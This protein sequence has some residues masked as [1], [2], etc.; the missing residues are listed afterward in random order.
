VKNPDKTNDGEFISAYECDPLIA[1]SEFQFAQRQYETITGR[2]HNKNSVIAY[3]L[4]QSFK[5]GEITPEL[6]NKLGY[7]LQKHIS[8]YG[9]TRD[10]Y[11]QYKK[12]GWNKKFYNEHEGEIIL[13]R[14]VKKFFDGL[15]YG[16]DKKLPTINMLKTEYAMILSEKKKL[17][18]EYK[19]ARENMIKLK[20]AKQN[21]ETFLNKKPSV[22]RQ[23]K[24]LEISR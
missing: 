22:E 3:H 4:R 7:E 17:Y 19:T 2:N 20:T 9:R 12:S 18:S 5:P 16:K 8:E 14:V 10:I 21:V 24:S 23:Q 6:A 13:H 1:D 11:A 15:G